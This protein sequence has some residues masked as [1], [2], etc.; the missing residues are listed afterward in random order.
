MEY[1]SDYDLPETFT[2]FDVIGSATC[3]LTGTADNVDKA[4]GLSWNFKN[5]FAKITG[6]VTHY[7]KKEGAGYAGVGNNTVTAYPPYHTAA[8]QYVQ[9]NPN[10]IQMISADTELQFYDAG[11]P[12]NVH[13]ADIYTNDY[14]KVIKVNEIITDLM[15]LVN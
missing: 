4:D 14:I 7:P 3:T 2:H 13:L 10:D 11:M 9:A 5:G 1:D 6:N 8:N 12:V 15:I